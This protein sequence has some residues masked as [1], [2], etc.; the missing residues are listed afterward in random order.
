MI[1][2]NLDDLEIPKDVM[3][4]TGRVIELQ[5]ELKGT[6]DEIVVLT[7]IGRYVVDAFVCNVGRDFVL[8]DDLS[9]ESV[10][11]NIPGYPR[12]VIPD[13]MWHRATKKVKGVRYTMANLTDKDLKA[14]AAS[15]IF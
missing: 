11:D 9:L 12:L 1:S 4:E 3:A 13:H 15:W 2:I 7:Y 10:V 5:G 6:D 8:P 14:V